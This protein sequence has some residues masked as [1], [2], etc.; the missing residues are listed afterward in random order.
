MQV[1]KRLT[2]GSARGK[3]AASITKFSKVHRPVRLRFTFLPAMLAVEVCR[4]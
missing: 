2:S 1:N 4:M 3:L